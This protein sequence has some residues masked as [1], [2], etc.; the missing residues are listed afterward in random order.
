M[1]RDPCKY[2]N[3]FDQ[4]RIFIIVDMVSSAAILVFGVESGDSLPGWLGIPLLLLSGCL[5]TLIWEGLSTGRIRSE[6]RYEYRAISPFH[7]WF[8]VIVYTI[9]SFFF[10]GFALYL[11]FTNF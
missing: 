4:L 8:S 2:R 11:L 5:L 10:I 1:R 6:R 9:I 3:I 7:F